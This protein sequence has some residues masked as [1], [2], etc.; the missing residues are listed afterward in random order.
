VWVVLILRT[1]LKKFSNFVQI[2]LFFIFRIGIKCPKTYRGVGVELVLFTNNQQ[3]V[4]SD[5]CKRLVGLVTRK[6]SVVV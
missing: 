3:R 2:P 4:S 6:T 1:V 5:G